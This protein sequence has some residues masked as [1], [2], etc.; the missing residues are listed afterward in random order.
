[1]LEQAH[2]A[3]LQS[4]RMERALW[5]YY[6]YLS[7]LRGKDERYVNHIAEEVAFSYEKE[8]DNW[9]IGWLLLYLAPEYSMSYA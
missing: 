9:R 2:N 8:P 4:D 1:M 6:L 7:T 3:I 5:C